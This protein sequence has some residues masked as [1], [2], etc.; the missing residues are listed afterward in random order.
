VVLQLG[1]GFAVYNSSPQK[2]KKT[3]T[4]TLHKVSGLEISFVAT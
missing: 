1:T 4:E 2:K 3:F